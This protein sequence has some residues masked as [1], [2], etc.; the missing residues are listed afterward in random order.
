M[1]SVISGGCVELN[2]EA[3]KV[4]TEEAIAIGSKQMR[5]FIDYQYRT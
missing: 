2:S 4:K 1:L 5:N 3:L